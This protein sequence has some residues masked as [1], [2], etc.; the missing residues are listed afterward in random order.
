MKVAELEGAQLDYWVARANGWRVNLDFPNGGWRYLNEDPVQPFP[1]EWRS[2]YKPSSDWS[3][4]GPIIERERFNIVD[5]AAYHHNGILKEYS[6]QFAAFKG[7]PYQLSDLGGFEFY[8]MQKGP[9][10]LIAA[11]RAY[12]ASKFGDTV[13][14]D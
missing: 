4:G 7:D 9:T 12:V 8:W 13:E 2:E 1:A 6:E 14:D 3:D 10:P 11:M 5:H